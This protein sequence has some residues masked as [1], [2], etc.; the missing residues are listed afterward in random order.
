MLKDLSARELMRS[1]D[2]F[3]FE[4]CGVRL[5]PL[6]L[7]AA[8]AILKSTCCGEGLSFSLSLPHADLQVLQ[9]HL[10]AYLLRMYNHSENTLLAIHP[11]PAWHVKAMDQLVEYLWG[12]IFTRN[13]WTR[14]GDDFT[15][16]S[17]RARFCH[18]NVTVLPEIPAPILLVLVNQIE[19]IPGLLID[20]RFSCLSASGNPTRVLFGEEKATGRKFQQ[21]MPTRT[22]NTIQRISRL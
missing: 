16:G 2:G 9:N 15:I 11:N 18:I 19:D 3:V 7:E 6:Q 17:C 14:Q 20:D 10:L 4:G 22:T 8:A 12:N 13:R 1:F 21:D 5:N